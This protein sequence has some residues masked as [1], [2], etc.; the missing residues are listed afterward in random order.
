MPGLY[1]CLGVGQPTGR[2][3]AATGGGQW[4]KSVTYA[5]F[6]T[7]L[8]ETGLPHGSARRPVMGELERRRWDGHESRQSATGAEQLRPGRGL[9]ESPAVQRGD[10]FGQPSRVTS[11]RIG[12]LAYQKRRWNGISSQVGIEGQ[13]EFDGWNEE[14]HP[15]P[16]SGE[17]DDQQ[18]DQGR[19]PRPRQSDW[20]IE[21]GA[22]LRLR[23]AS[24]GGRKE[25]V[26]PSSKASPLAWL[27][28]E[29]AAHLVPIDLKRDSK[30]TVRCA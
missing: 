18:K 27:S 28:N 7:V 30:G 26:T 4:A 24:S 22:G 2:A 23:V 3:L 19:L 9:T 6:L 29:I 5:S 1:E 8:L 16:L 10:P 17:Q 21:M 12:R 15:T 11:P 14:R 20:R 13:R 25:V